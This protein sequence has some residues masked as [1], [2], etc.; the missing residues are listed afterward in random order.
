MTSYYSL[1]TYNLSRNMYEIREFELIEA[2][3][4]L[5]D[6]YLSPLNL[7]SFVD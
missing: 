5:E 2:M 6:T 3:F 4:I 1:T 7:F